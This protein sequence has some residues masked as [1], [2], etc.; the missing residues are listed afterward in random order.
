[1]ESDLCRQE[2][3]NCQ[4]EMPFDGSDTLLQPLYTF[5]NLSI[6]EWMSAR[7]SRNC[8]SRKDRSSA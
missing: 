1:M 2:L 5:L 8:S 4:A 6:G 3:L 7:I